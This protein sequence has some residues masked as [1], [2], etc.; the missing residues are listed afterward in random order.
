MCGMATVKALKI[1]PLSGLAYQV[2]NKESESKS[3]IYHMCN[4]APLW[5]EKNRD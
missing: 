5:G 2:F 4:L 3:Q 1:L